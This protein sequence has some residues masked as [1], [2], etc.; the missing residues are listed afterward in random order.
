MLHLVTAT[1]N[2]EACPAA[3]DAAKE[4]ALPGISRLANGDMPPGVT[5]VGAWV[6]MPG[7]ALYAVVDAPNAHEI[8]DF[9]MSAGFGAYS[10]VNVTP[11][12]EIESLHRRL[13]APRTR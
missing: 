1:H 10:T 6:N 4:I 12:V 2:P 9:C 8:V 7:H 13:L 11:V 3:F 5:L